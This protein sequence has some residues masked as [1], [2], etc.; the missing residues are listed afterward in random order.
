MHKNAL[1]AGAPLGKL[2][3]PTPYSWIFG[4]VRAGKGRRG[5]GEG[6]MRGREGKRKGRKGEW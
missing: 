6:R 4:E 3:A 5:K 2:I 1:A